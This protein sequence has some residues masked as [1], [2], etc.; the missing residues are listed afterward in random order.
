MIVIK[1]DG[2]EQ[3][4]NIEKVIAAVSKSAARCMRELTDIEKSNIRNSVTNMAVQYAHD[5]DG[6]IPISIMHIFA[7][8]ALDEIDESI[9]KAYREYRNYKQ[10]FCEML[11]SIYT[12]SQAIRYIG[13]V[14]NAN[15]DSAMIS[16]Q[17]SLI[18]GQ[19]NKNLYQKFFL[20]KEDLQ[21]TN[22]G[23]IYIHDMKDRL[24]GFNCILFDISNV[25]NG[26]F[27]MGNQW[28]NEPKS[29]SAAFNV[30]SDVTMSAASQ[31]YGGFTLPRIDTVLAKYAEKSYSIYYQEYLSIIGQWQIV[32]EDMLRAADKYAENKIERDF[33]QGFQSWECTFNTVGSSRGDYPFIACSFGIDT[34]RWGVMAT[35]VICRVRKNG[36]GKEGHKKVVLF[37]KLNF[38][39]DENLH[40]IGKP[41]E[42]LFNEAI[43]CS[44]KAMYPDYV[45]LTGEGYIPSMYKKYGK[46]ISL[47]GRDLLPM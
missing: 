8:K 37:P 30:I 43:E 11:D 38:L 3:Q 40:G 39:Y 18:Y 12:K 24:D 23:Y 27:E 47:M 14:S 17:R 20:N 25:L 28:V 13:D 36:Q 44:M 26:G 29:L 15:T 9:A 32:D 6:K 2:T 16:T 31:Q 42:Y 7:E 4:F 33:E 21:A 1:K 19:L 22:D 10:E 5:N 35:R 46:V 41:Y 34:S 45:S